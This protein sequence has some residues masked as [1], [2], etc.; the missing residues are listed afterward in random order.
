VRGAQLPTAQPLSVRRAPST[1]GT[2]PGPDASPPS[3]PPGAAAAPASG[4]PGRS[5]T[6]GAP[7]AADAH[8]AAGPTGGQ[9]VADEVYS[10]LTDFTAGVQRGLDAATPEDPPRD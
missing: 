10:F 7:D 4:S 3:P 9:E 8:G 6:P 1:T 2:P 5:G